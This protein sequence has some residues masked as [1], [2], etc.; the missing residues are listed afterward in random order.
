MAQLT[1]VIQT[2][3]T[4]GDEHKNLLKMLEKLQGNRLHHVA[5]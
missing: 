3:I 4:F 1:F 5:R 2:P